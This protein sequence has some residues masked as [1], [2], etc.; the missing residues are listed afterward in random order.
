MENRTSAVAKVDVQLPGI[1]AEA[2][3][4]ARNHEV[5]ARTLRDVLEHIAHRLPG[6]SVHLFDE[7]GAFREHVLCFLNEEST[8]WMESVDVPLHD[9][10]KIT[11]LQAVSG[12]VALRASWRHIS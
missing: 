5:Q 3:G 8:R 7:T 2:L 9:G 4:V 1:V 12:G 11:I 6:L 10:D